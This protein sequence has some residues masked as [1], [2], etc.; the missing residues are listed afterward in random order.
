MRV[1]LADFIKEKHLK[2]P[3]FLKKHATDVYQVLGEDLYT[4]PPLKDCS[5]YGWIEMIIERAH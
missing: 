5:G 2:I 4:F 3:Y 1:A